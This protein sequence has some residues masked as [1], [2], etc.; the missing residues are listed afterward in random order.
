MFVSIERVGGTRRDIVVDNP[1]I[2]I[3]CWSTSRLEAA[4]LA[5]EVDGILPDFRYSDPRITSIERDALY[6][7]PDLKGKKP[8]Y[9]IV[10]DITTA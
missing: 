8:R 3:Q 2:A 7:H 1:S 9:Q 5:Y 10:V 6:N 4:E